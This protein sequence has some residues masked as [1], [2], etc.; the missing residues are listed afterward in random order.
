MAAVDLRS[1]LTENADKVWQPKEYLAVEHEITALQYAGDWAGSYPVILVDN[2]LMPDGS[3]S[4]IPVLC[5]MT[6][7]RELTAKVLGLSDHRLAGPELFQRISGAIEPISVKSGD[8]PV[9]EV[10]LNGTDCNLEN[11]PALKQ[12]VYDPGRYLTAAHATTYDPDTGVDNTAIQRCWIKGPRKMTYYAVPSSHNARNMRKFWARGE[13]C[14]IAFWIGHHPAVSIGS[15]VKQDYPQ[16]H[17]STVGGFLSEP[18]RLVPSITHGEKIM[19]P[20]DA[21]IV[22]EGWIPRDKMEPDGPFGEY[23]GYSGPQVLAPYCEVSCITR[24]QEAIYH[25]YGSGLTDM[26][27]PDNM[28]MEVKLFGMA[29]EVTPA[30]NAIHVPVSGRR[31]HAYLKLSDPMAGEARDVLAAVLAYRRLKM[32]VSVDDDIDIFDEQEINWALSTRVQWERDSFQLSGLSG[33]TLDPSLPSG[34]RTVSKIGIDATLPQSELA[35]APKP[36]LPRS[37]VPDAALEN[38]VEMFSAAK[39]V[40]W[41][42]Q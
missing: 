3:R 14:P 2:P 6:A 5:N 7:S 37:V 28:M 25:D 19:V 20:A 1:F 35:G 4:D 29:R 21:E 8:A 36:T 41:S 15:Q 26:L 27:V 11:L 17:W 24:R 31:F 22:V 30:V 13:D 34:A 39:S 32:A 38:A 33:S 23:H 10:V 12:H 40:T 9:Q 18:L 42:E 16:S